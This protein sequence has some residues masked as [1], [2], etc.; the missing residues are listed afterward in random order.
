MRVEEG[1]KRARGES[2]WWTKILRFQFLFCAI[3]ERTQW[4]LRSKGGVAR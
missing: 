4:T 1:S 2:S 3:E